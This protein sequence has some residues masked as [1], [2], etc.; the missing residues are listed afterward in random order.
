MSGLSMGEAVRYSRKKPQPQWTYYV[1][2]MTD[3]A[4]TGRF[5]ADKITQVYE[6]IAHCFRSNLR[7]IGVVREKRI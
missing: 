7:I 4:A 3:K 6:L 1:E 2:Y 5:K